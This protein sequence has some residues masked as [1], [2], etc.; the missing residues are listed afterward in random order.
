MNLKNIQIQLCFTLLLSICCLMTLQG[1]ASFK[2]TPQDE[3]LFKQHAQTKTD[4]DIR[5]SCTVLTNEESKYIFDIDLA[6]RF[7][8]AVWLEVEN[9]D[10]RPYWLLSSAI[11][12]NYYSPDEMAYSNRFIMS[13]KTNEEMVKIF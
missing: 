12:N 1:C 9:N 6:S 4:G 10:D 3:V 11:D 5:V 13:E 2:P 8:Q 7:I